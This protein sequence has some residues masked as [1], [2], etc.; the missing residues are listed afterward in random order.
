MPDFK[1]IAKNGWHPKTD[2][3]FSNPKKSIKGLLGKGEEDERA[4]HVAAPLS[5][6][7]D[8]ASFGPPPKRTNTG[9]SPPP[10]GQAYQAPA[11]ANTARPSYNSAQSAQSTTTY[12]HPGY[13]QPA[14]QAEEPPAPPRPYRVDTTGLSTANLPP[15][16][17]RRPGS[18][19]PVSTPSP[20][21]PHTGAYAKPKP[22]PP[23]ALPPRL[24]PRGAGASPSPSAVTAPHPPPTQQPPTYLNTTAISR[25][26]SAG[27][28]VPGFGIGSSSPST[29]PEPQSTGTTFA[30]KR[31]ALQTASNLH[32][33]PSSVSASDISSAAS[34]VNNFQS[35][36]GAQIG[37]VAGHVG[38]STTGT[39]IG[40]GALVAGK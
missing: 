19:T 10:L 25:L 29:T 26:S 16:P 18:I 38:A 36:H 2:V 3:D 22:N 6:L 4:N 30:E 1:S 23:P 5:S 33:N 15:P 28:S 9:L 21:P 12:Q 32:R 40:A 31:A 39:G 20:P 35:R 13:S 24:P 37:A 27:V 8:P 14:A 17:V 7:R 11:T 34:T